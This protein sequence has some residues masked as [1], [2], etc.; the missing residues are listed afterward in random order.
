MKNLIVVFLFSLALNGCSDT[1]SSQLEDTDI[2]ANTLNSVANLTR[3]SDQLYN[4]KANPVVLLTKDKTDVQVFIEELRLGALRIND[5]QTM[6]SQLKNNDAKTMMVTGLSKL[7]D[8]YSRRWEYVK[9][10][11]PC[12]R[13]KDMDEILECLEEINSIHK[14][15][16]ESLDIDAMTAMLYFSGAKQAVG[17]PIALTEFD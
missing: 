5:L 9:D 4:T 7:T 10:Q 12:Y 13:L 6:Q 8:V 17:L 15:S 2:V 11:A 1:N 14:D 3:Q 16:I